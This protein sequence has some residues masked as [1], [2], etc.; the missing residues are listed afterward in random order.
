MK[1]LLLDTNIY[2]ALADDSETR[3]AL[4]KAI[5]RGKLKVIVTPIIR[6]ELADGPLGGIPDWFP[7]E[8]EPETVAVVGF[9]R[10]GLA[11]LGS[12]QVFTRHRGQSS[13]NEDAIIADSAHTL[14]DIL[15][16]NDKRAA[17][18]LREIISDSRT[19]NFDDLK[20]LVRQSDS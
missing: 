16:T 17:R 18:R 4:W 9:W 8:F 13:Q 1:T 5:E 2:N 11:R 14:A 20:R 3:A 10:I 7:I 15:V 19:M 6:D 12:G